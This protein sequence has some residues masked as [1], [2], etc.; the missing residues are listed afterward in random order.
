MTRRKSGGLGFL[1]HGNLACNILKEDLIVRVGP[2]QYDELL[3]QPG[4][5]AFDYT[6]RPIKGWIKVVSAGHDSEEKLAAWVKRG[7]DFALSL[8][9]K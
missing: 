1:L 5:R 8:P 9:P 6:G 7:A 3:K 4:T 2:D